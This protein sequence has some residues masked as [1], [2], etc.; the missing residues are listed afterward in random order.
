MERKHNIYRLF[1]IPLAALV[2]FSTLVL[3]TPGQEAHA[4]AIPAFADYSPIVEP[5]FY[6][7]VNEQYYSFNL[8]LLSTF[9]IDPVTKVGNAIVRDN[10]TNQVIGGWEYHFE[11][12]VTPTK[13]YLAFE[14]VIG[15]IDEI[16]ILTSIRL[17]DDWGLTEDRLTPRQYWSFT[18]P[19][20]FETY[21]FIQWHYFHPKQQ[22]NH[23]IMNPTPMT[24]F[25]EGVYNEG[26]EFECHTNMAGALTFNEY[27]ECQIWPF[28]EIYFFNFDIPVIPTQLLGSLNA[29]YFNDLSYDYE[30][31]QNVTVV[32]TNLPDNWLD[33]LGTVLDGFFGMEIFPNF[34][35]G[36]VFIAV[37]AIMFVFF[38]I[39]MIK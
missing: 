1:C 9:T 38:V 28:A 37:I 15:P 16:F 21:S 18:C 4:E 10:I 11:N 17:F 35:L 25:I 32:E 24:N 2:L 3:F 36:M 33:W 20:Y 12:V 22:G 7:E 30:L 31:V 34:T 27:H 13:A 14:S 8:P 23:M 39:K 19:A 26:V 6:I 5:L 29:N